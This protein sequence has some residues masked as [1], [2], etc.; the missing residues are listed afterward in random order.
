MSKKRVLFVTDVRGWSYDDR[1]KNWKDMLSHMFDID[2]MYLS[3]YKPVALGHGLARLIKQ[4]QSDSL[5]GTLICADEL[6]DSYNTSL[7][8]CEVPGPVFDHMD[9]DG[10]YFFYHRALCDSRLLG[11]PIPMSKVGVAINNEKWLDKTAEVEFSDYMRGAKVITGCNLNIMN[12][13][14]KFD[15]NIVRVSQCINS[16]VFFEARKYFV[17]NRVGDKFVVGWA[18]A[19][20][21][22]IKNLPMVKRACSRSGVSLLIAS[23]LN[24]KQLNLWYNKLDAV[25][26]ASKS[27]GGPLMLLEAG[28][29]GIP[30]ISTPVGLSREIIV[31][32]K[33]GMVTEWSS[34]SISNAINVL[35]ASKSIR[36][37]LGKALQGEVLRRWTYKARICEIK[38][39]L[40]ILTKK[41]SGGIKYNK[42]YTIMCDD[43]HASANK[44]KD[45][46][47]D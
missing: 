38:R 24:R 40:R 34:E 27:E 12:T 30:V 10:V 23:D 35:S 45:F 13:F 42:N 29:V 39:A 20:N 47:H 1:A 28:A 44:S 46:D 8:K 26:C 37:R 33:T 21:N 43:E 14:S 32:N 19:R 11:T 22:S 5:S 25:V 15:R 31:H 2:I 17:S 9:Y 41:T 3:D 18:G 36:G 4:Y 16:K 6:L 7:Y